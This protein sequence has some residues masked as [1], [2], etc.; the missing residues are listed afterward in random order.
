MFDKAAGKNQ[1]HPPVA[2]PGKVL[3]VTINKS[4]FIVALFGQQVFIIFHSCQL[5]AVKGK[6]FACSAAAAA[7]FQRIV[8]I[9]LTEVSQYQVYLE[10]TDKLFPMGS[11]P[12]RFELLFCYFETF[13]HFRVIL[14]HNATEKA[15]YSDS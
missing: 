3:C 1:I 15:D 14:N 4:H 12:N 11:I 10:L 9:S 8:K 6:M 13:G 7:Q 5:F 2:E